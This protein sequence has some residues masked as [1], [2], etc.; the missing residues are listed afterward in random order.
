MTGGVVI[1]KRVWAGVAFQVV[2]EKPEDD[3]CAVS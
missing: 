1:V 2:V 3:S